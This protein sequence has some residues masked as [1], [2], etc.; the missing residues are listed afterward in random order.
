[1][2]QT[3]FIR[4][5]IYSIYLI[6]QRKSKFMIGFALFNMFC[7]WY[8]NGQFAGKVVA[9]LP[10]EPWGSVSS[11]SHRNIEGDDMTQVAPFFIFTLAGVSFR[12]M[13]GK[14]LGHEGPRMPLD[15]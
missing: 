5:Y 2:P 8:I 1:M 11:M 15:H 6:Y 7:M 4:K 9:K 12:G 14:I 3:T 10:F 13:L